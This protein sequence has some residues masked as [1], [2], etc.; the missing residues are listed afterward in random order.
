MADDF[1]TH[2]KRQREQR[3]ISLEEV[4]TITKIHVRYLKALE[5]NQ[6]DD[7]PGEVFI[8][9][10]I[11]SYGRAIGANVNELLETYDQTVGNE[12][13]EK[14][15][16]EIRKDENETRKQVTLVNTFVGG[17]LVLFFLF[18]VWY[19][20][21]NPPQNETSE[22]A[23]KAPPAAAST[24]SENSKPSEKKLTPKTE[25]PD[26]DSGEGETEQKTP[27]EDKPKEESKPSG[28]ETKT[29]AAEKAVS[30]QA[31]AE[32]GKK[33]EKPVSEKENS[34]I[35][36]NQKTQQVQEDSGRSAEKSEVE[37]PL[38]LA[39][40]VT[41]NA[42]FN[43]A[44][45]GSEQRDFI[46]PAGETKEFKAQEGFLLTI[47][48]RRGTHLKLNGKVLELPASSDNVVRGF[49]V[50]AKSIE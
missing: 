41:E 8:K 19:L 11:R 7:L 5:D 15:R 24:A 33:V 16:Q 20:V 4:T 29:Q 3:G 9:G 28:K 40:E 22:N 46:L 23:R 1:G 39:I 42:W 38:N 32:S 13:I 30:A 27:S 36:T 47:G 21:V 49:Q 18:A 25:S 43:M 35:I 31:G 14:R 34:A 44:V 2:L 50:N 45:D 12:R 17:F 10:F 6:F 26:S 37:A 48:N